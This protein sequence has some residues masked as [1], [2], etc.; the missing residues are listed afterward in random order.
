MTLRSM[1]NVHTSRS[2][3]SATKAGH[4]MLRNWAKTRSKASVFRLGRLAPMGGHRALADP[5]YQI[6]V[7]DLPLVESTM[8]Y[9]DFIA[10]QSRNFRKSLRRSLAKQEHINIEVRSDGYCCLDAVRKVSTN[11]WKFKE[12]TAIVSEPETEKFFLS[13]L[14]QIPC[15]SLVQSRLVL[16][17]DTEA[18]DES[19]GFIICLTF[20]GRL[21]AIKMGLDERVLD[22]SP[23][24]GAINAVVA[25]AC[26]D[27]KLELVDLDARGPHGDYK[28]R[29]ANKV[30]T[31]ETVLGFAPD[32]MGRTARS[33]WKLKSKL[34]SIRDAGGA[35]PQLPGE[36]L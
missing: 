32:V 19:V 31:V 20:N 12:G 25:H 1:G 27:P 4:E 28:M 2:A 9:D 11:T 26:A 8:T 23:G 16:M 14:D 15:A 22:V 29:W 33:L 6:E 24:M 21:Y 13:L 36:L 7:V 34:K 18:G 10:G 30:E 17:K 35:H 3:V 5:L